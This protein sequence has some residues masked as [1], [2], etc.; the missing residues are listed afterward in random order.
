MSCFLPFVNLKT[1]LNKVD[2][3]YYKFPTTTPHINAIMGTQNP[4]DIS[5]R[6]DELIEEVFDRFVKQINIWLDWF[7]KF[8]DIFLYIIEWLRNY[9]MEKVD[10]FYREMYGPR[11]DSTMTLLKM[12]TLVQEILKGFEPFTQLP[13][14]CDM[15]NCTQSFEII[16]PGT[17]STQDQHKP[18]IAETEQ[19]RPNDTFKINANTT[20][21]K[22]HR[23]DDRRHVRW[24]LAC[25]QYPYHVV[26]EYQLN[27]RGEFKTQRGG[28]LRMLI[29][30]PSEDLQHTLWFQ[31]KSNALSTCHLFHGIF[32]IHYQKYFNSSNTII[33]KNDLS[34]LMDRTFLFIDNLLD[35]SISLAEMD[36]LRMVFYDKNINV[37]EEVH[38]LFA[39]QSI[40]TTTTATTSK[41]SSNEKIEQVYKWLQTYQYYSHVNIIID[42][43]E[44]F[45]IISA[46]TNDESMNHLQGLTIDTSR[47]L[48]E[49]S[50]T[51]NDFYHLF[52]KLSSEHL[53]L[54]KTMVACPNV[55]EMMKKSNLYST[56]GLRRF[57]ELRD[58]LTTQFQLQERNNMILNSWIITFTLCEP[59]VH[60]AR[61][62]EQF[63]DNLARL[64]IIDENS[65]EHIKGKSEFSCFGINRAAIN[66]EENSSAD[67]Y[68]KI[69]IYPDIEYY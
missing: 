26:I 24:S 14:L 3:S 5:I 8:V 45:H 43:V 36:E 20:D 53:Q 13:R 33:R 61:D 56:D 17:L 67:A 2:L 65:C 69:Q 32:N 49:I 15:F 6:E 25:E 60:N 21:E 40:A 7:K 47:S 41:I 23:I 27:L 1:I 66:E 4:T 50:D 68:A 34:E 16:D 64:T 46:E 51:Y 22:L 31:I 59:F 55:V 54:I 39:N 37:R 9:K 30:N 48:K 11:D 29:S 44:K 28:H 12:K 62:L 19:F 18:C 63:V 35:G 57:Q 38:K 58:N 10:Q 42:C 52:Q